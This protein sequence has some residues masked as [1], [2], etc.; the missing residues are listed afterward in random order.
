MRKVVVVNE[1][2]EV[3]RRFHVRVRWKGGLVGYTQSHLARLGGGKGR[4]RSTFVEGK[5]AFF[6]DCLEEDVQRSFLDVPGARIMTNSL[7]AA[8]IPTT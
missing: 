7:P 3:E 2:V 6:P 8:A 5:E 4:G 1:E